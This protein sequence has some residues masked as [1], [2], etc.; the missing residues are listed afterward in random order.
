MYAIEMDI[1]EPVPDKPGY[2][3]YVEGRPANA[4]FIELKQRLENTGY[5]PDEY[6]LLDDEWRDGRKIP[7]DAELSIDVN[8]GGSEGIYM[9]IA[10][11]WTE[12][13]EDKTSWCK[14]HFI[15]GKTLGESQSDMDR[16]FL[17]ASA[18]RQAFHSDGVHARYIVIGA[19]EKRLS[20][21]VAHLNTEEIELLVEDLL[22]VR[23]KKKMDGVPFVAEEKLL[24]R[25]LGSI[26]EYM[27]TVGEKPTGIVAHDA[28]ILAIQENDLALFQELLPSVADLYNEL[29]VLAAGQSGKVCAKMTS[30]LLELVKDVPRE[31]YLQAIKRAIEIGDIP[32]IAMLLDGSETR[33]ED[34]DGTLYSEAIRIALYDTTDEISKSYIAET[35]ARQAEPAQ[36]AAADSRLLFQ[37]IQL[38]PRHGSMMLCYLLHAGID[39][40]QHQAR[41]YHAVALSRRLHMF[42][43]L[44]EHGGDINAENYGALRMC[45]DNGDICT[46]KTL[47]DN[48]ADYKSFRKSVDEKLLAPASKLFLEALDN[49][50]KIVD[51]GGGG[52]DNGEQ[53]PT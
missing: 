6:F 2:V 50:Y 48:G 20:G 44:N 15:T 38:I 46:A 33:T 5:L 41:L 25:L 43:D 1:Y 8:Y 37:S 11:H 53:N 24:R 42:R 14:K 4:V 39:I 51:T 28:I 7:K 23:A 22:E 45:L 13:K 31:Q 52:K 29:L 21:M 40:S 36:L 26:I 47:V 19:K 9:D 12:K 3:R 18:I 17:I 35:L 10:L 49:H 34:P 32:R 30:S 16:M 27:R